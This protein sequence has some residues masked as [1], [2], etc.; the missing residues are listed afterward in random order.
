MPEYW[1]ILATALIT[2]GATYLAYWLTG[3]PRLIAFSP[4]STGFE[5]R[6]PQEGT[7]PIYIRAGQVVVQNVGRKSAKQVQLTA[8]PGTPMGYN[9]LPNLDHTVRSGARGEWIL[10]FPFLGPRETV[11]VQILNGP[12]IDTIRSI[13]GP[14]KIVPVIHQRLFPAWFNATA[15]TLTTVGV[16]TLCYGA[17]GLARWLIRSV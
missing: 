7:Q 6:S 12:N 2:L 15:L 3:K 10:E 9:V 13:D 5:L 1:T 17:Y 8:Q 4:A 14:A 11:T 16:I